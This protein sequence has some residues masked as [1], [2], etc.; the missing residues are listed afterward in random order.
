MIV[1]IDVW[2]FPHFGHFTFVSVVLIF[3][4]FVF[5]FV[6]QWV[7]AQRVERVRGP[8]FNDF[9]PNSAIFHYR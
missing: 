7:T 9:Q 8:Y 1:S 3:I 6:K 2:H 5:E 4:P